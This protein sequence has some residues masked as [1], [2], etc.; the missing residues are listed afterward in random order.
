MK[1]GEV[2]VAT[3][4]FGDTGPGP[5]QRGSSRGHILDG[6]TASLARL[7]LDY[8]DLYQLHGFDPATPIEETLGALNDPFDLSA[9]QPK[10]EYRIFP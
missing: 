3:K 4:V 6:A 10:G 1:R 7:K 2:I 9:R 8:I 5:N